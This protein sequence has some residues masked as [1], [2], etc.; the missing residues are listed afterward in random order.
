MRS[1]GYKDEASLMTRVYVGAEHNEAAWR[2]RM[3]EALAFLIGR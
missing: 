1:S 3:G 2:V